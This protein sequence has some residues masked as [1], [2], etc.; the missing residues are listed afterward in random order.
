[1]QSVITTQNPKATR[2]YQGKT[3]GGHRLIHE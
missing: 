1:M 3:K 2:K